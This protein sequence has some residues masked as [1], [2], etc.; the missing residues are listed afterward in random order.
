M[1]TNT[2]ATNCILTVENFLRYFFNHGSVPKRL[3]DDTKKRADAK[4]RF[5]PPKPRPGL[6]ANGPDGKSKSRA[7]TGADSSI[8]PLV[9]LK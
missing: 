3:A 8:C 2:L 1:A 6:E 4:S 5:N 9:G 7:K